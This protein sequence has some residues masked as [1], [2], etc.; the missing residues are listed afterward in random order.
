MSEY[1]KV[2]GGKLRFKNEKKNTKNKVK[3]HKK[4][5]LEA[6]TEKVDDDATL[7]GGWW[8]V[9]TFKEIS[10]PI[11]IE[12]Q[13]HCY[14]KALDNGQ[15]VLGGPHETGSGPEPE[16]ILTA[17]PISDSKIALK[18]GYNKYLRVGM[19]GRLYGRSDAIGSMEQWEPVF[20]D[21]KLAI[22]SAQ[23][24]FISVDDQT[25]DV[26]AISKKAEENEILKIRSSVQKEK[27][28]DD[29]PIEEKGSIS[30]CEVNYV[31]KFQSFQDR[32]LRVNTE[33]KVVVKKAKHEGNLHEVLLDRRAK[34]KS[35]KFC[36]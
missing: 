14:M 15:F 22:S 10:G 25:S 16:E 20:Q 29:I 30:S 26:V 11:A 1:A 27:E 23:N 4:R 3:V 2:K 33:D 8:S 32:R 12:F 35:D 31:K 9:S 13:P 18:S 34:M 36:K 7:H 28:K 24:C 6:E 21:G 5:K 17:I 19:D